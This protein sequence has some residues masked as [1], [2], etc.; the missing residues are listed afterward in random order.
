MTKGNEEARI[1][2]HALLGALTA[3]VQGGNAGAGAAG[4]A[5]AA[6]STDAIMQALY[7]TTDVKELSESQKQ[8]V[9]ALV[10]MASGVAGGLIGGNSAAAI[11]AAQAG[12]NAAENND[13]VIFPP[14]LVATS[15]AA[16][17]YGEY[18]VLHGA[19]AQEMEAGFKAIREGEGFEGPDAAKGLIQAWTIMI[20]GPLSATELSVGAAAMGLGA[21]ISAGANTGYQLTKDEPFSYGDAFIAG[22]VG[23]LTQGKGFWVTQGAGLSSSYLG[24][25]I[26]GEDPAYPL[27]GSFVGTTI[28][29]KGGPVISNV[30]KPYVGDTSAEV[31]GNMAGSFTSEVAGDAVQNFGNKK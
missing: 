20:A 4:A 15:Q 8:T 18:A 26:K 2:A 25:L 22:V 27:L 7:G 11:A 24:S 10:T 29:F 31:F 9:S 12:K 19:S 5:L 17:S 6:G 28:G 21:A 13:M 23:G 3:S 16:A 30:L 14:G 1:M